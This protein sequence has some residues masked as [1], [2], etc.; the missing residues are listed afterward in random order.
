MKRV[1]CYDTVGRGGVFIDVTVISRV[2]YRRNCEENKLP[3]Y[4]H[5]N[6]VGHLHKSH[7]DLY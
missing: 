5:I 4:E 1:V 6:T 7:I 2:Q 3:A